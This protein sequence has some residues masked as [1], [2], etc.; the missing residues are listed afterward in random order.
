MDNG[1]S[2]KKEQHSDTRYTL[3]GIILNEISQSPND[4]YYIS[5]LIG[6]I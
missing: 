3:E 5:P 6:H 2:L 1:T 4:K